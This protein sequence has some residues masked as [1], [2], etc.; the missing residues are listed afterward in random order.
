VAYENDHGRRHTS[1]GATR[2][3]LRVWRVLAPHHQT[4]ATNETATRMKLHAH[5]THLAHSALLLSAFLV[6]LPLWHIGFCQAASMRRC[7]PMR[8]HLQPQGQVKIVR[9]ALVAGSSH[10]A[11]DPRLSFAIAMLI[12]AR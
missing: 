7:S 3:M 4:D 9:H 11:V 5:R 2:A 6:K 10:G 8:A 1:L 12:H